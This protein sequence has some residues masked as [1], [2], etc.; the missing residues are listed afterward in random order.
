MLVTVTL[1]GPAAAFAHHSFAAEFDSNG[2][3]TLKGASTKVDFVNPHAWLYMNV[4]DANGKVVNWAIEM[5]APNTLIRRG[6]TKNT[7]PVGVE[8]TVQGFRAKDGSATAN[9]QTIKMPDGTQLFAGS[10][11]TPG[12]APAGERQ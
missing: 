5:G 12:G 8:V 6:F 1:L 9:G 3:V 11:T 2:Q 7:V 4:T 10:N